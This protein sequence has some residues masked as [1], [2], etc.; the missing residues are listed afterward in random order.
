MA[1]GMTTVFAF[2]GLLVALMQASA[3]FFEAFGDRFAEPEA[4]TPS[5]G[6]PPDSAG[7]DDEIAIV[8]AAIE[9]HRRGGAGA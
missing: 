8:L 4:P 9:A 3:A 1:V 2:L 5:P 7:N 6:T